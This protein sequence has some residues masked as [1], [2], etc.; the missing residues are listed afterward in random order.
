MLRHL[1]EAVGRTHSNQDDW[2][3][4]KLAIRSGAGIRYLN[5]DPVHRLHLARV[6]VLVATRVPAGAIR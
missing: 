1:A 2:V 4:E 3:L 6:P 5:Y